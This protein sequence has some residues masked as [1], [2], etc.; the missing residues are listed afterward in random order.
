MNKL[1]VVFITHVIISLLALGAFITQ[2]IRTN[3][4]LYIGLITSI[5]TFWLKPPRIRKKKTFIDKSKNT[6]TETNN[7]YHVC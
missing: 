3:N 7:D 1:S 5:V 6:N 2:L 4:Q